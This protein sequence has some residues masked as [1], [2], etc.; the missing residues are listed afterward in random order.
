MSDPC[1]T[2]II[3]VDDEA[4]IRMHGAS[5]LEDAGYSVVEAANADEAIAILEGT[6]DVRLLF[7]DVDMPGSMNGVAL[8]E[9]VHARWPNV[10][11]LLT[12]GHH[13]IANAQLPD[14]GRFIPKPYSQKAVVRE[15]NSLLHNGE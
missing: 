7:S 11:L 2:T 10:R 6:T 5:M 14:D 9:V 8:A 1:D 3:V 13:H 15:V 4:L 12:S